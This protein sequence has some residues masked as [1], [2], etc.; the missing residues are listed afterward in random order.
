MFTDRTEATIIAIQD[1][2]GLRCTRDK[3]EP[4]LLWLLEQERKKSRGHVPKEADKD[5]GEEVTCIEEVPPESEKP[6]K[7]NDMP[8]TVDATTDL[9]HLMEEKA[10]L[11]EESHSLDKEQDKLNSQVKMLCEKIIQEKK[12]RNSE[13]Q[14]EISKLQESIANLE[15]QLGSLSPLGTPES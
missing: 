3:N 5:S 11:K 2:L 9:E 15:A 1:S 13:K 4:V 14:K 12:R 6:R 7:D 10:F 8:S